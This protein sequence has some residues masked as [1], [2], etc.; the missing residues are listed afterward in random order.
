VATV[1][2]TGL[3]DAHNHLLDPTGRAVAS[4]R[5]MTVNGADGRPAG[6]RRTHGP[7]RVGVRL[8][9]AASGTGRLKRYQTPLV[10]SDRPQSLN[11]RSCGT[12]TPHRPS[13]QDAR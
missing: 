10:D 13:T 1:E 4:L 6:A 9:L 12:A 7:P 11:A 5:R 2:D 8:G 3:D